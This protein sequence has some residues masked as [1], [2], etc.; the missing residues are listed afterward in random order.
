MQDLN[1]IPPH[2]PG[3]LTESDIP[4]GWRLLRDDELSLTDPG[5]FYVKG[6]HSRA[7]WK[8]RGDSRWRDGDLG[9]EFGLELTVI[10][11][12]EPKPQLPPKPT[13]WPNWDRL[14]K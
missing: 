1:S 9:R 3:G 8:R 10:V 12:G 4:E 13:R 6:T 7:M 2:N 14:C 11:P 5:Y